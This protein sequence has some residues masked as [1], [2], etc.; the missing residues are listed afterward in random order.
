MDFSKKQFLSVAVGCLRRKGE[1]REIFSPTVPTKKELA[2]I[3]KGLKT[4]VISKKLLKKF[5]P[6]AYAGVSKHGFTKYYFKVHNKKIRSL[7]RY[8]KPKLVEWCTVQ[9]ATVLNKKGKKYVVRTSRGKKLAVGN[10]PYPGIHSCNPKELKKGAKV[11][12]HR[13]NLCL[14]LHNK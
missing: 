11:L 8:V 7:E 9:K 13:A 10:E 3:K 2:Q 1:K 12:I 5:F 14:I 6:M 4:G